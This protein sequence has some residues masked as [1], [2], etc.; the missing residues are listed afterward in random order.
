MAYLMTNPG[1]VLLL[2]EPDAHLEILRQSQIYRLLTQV[3][4]A[5]RMFER[6]FRRLNLPNLLR[7]SDYHEL[8]AF[9]KPSD[10]D[11]EVGDVLDMIN[12]VA[13]AA[14]PRR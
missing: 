5:N 8:A 14:A 3:G 12:D 1:S 11:S 7:K 4:H 6:F 13:T 10:L 9:V 2:D